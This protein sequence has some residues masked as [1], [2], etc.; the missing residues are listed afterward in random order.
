MNHHGYERESYLMPGYDMYA[1]RSEVVW[2]GD[3]VDCFA[4]DEAKKLMSQHFPWVSAYRPFEHVNI[5]WATHH[6]RTGWTIGGWVEWVEEPSVDWVKIFCAHHP[7]HGRV[8]G[9]LSRKTW[10]E[11]VEGYEKFMEDHPPKL[12]RFIPMWW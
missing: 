6:P 4:A 2:S 1:F 8:W 10:A 9:D 12:L 11:S 3:P 7:V 5:D